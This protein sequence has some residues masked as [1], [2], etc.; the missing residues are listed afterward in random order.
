MIPCVQKIS[1]NEVQ[2]EYLSANVLSKQANKYFLLYW[3]N[4]QEDV[5]GKKPG[6]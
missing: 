3:K 1:I 5:F 4:N 6:L 2:I